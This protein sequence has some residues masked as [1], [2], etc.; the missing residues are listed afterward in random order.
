M[1]IAWVSQGT[2]TSATVSPATANYPTTTTAGNL[3]ILMVTNK[4][5]TSSPDTPSGW[6]KIGQKS[7]GI[8]ANGNDAGTMYITLFAKI[9]TGSEG[10]TTLSVSYTGTIN[11]SLLQMMQ[12]SKTQGD[13]DWKVASGTDAVA[14]TSWSVATNSGGLDIQV[15]DL[16]FAF[17]AFNGDLCT[18]VAS[19]ALSQTGTTFG[20]MTERWDDR[21]SSGSDSGFFMSEHPISSGGGQGEVTHTATMTGTGTST[22]TGP[23]I[24]LRLRENFYPGWVDK[25]AAST[26]L[27][28]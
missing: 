18:A 19:E 13:W 17:G 10:G 8:G 1:T 14:D 9:A 25:A 4:Y 28:M 12:V 11:T 16:V 21:S 26:L 22:P 23:G 6:V 3:L 24:I 27:R 2:R 5:D 20:T 7:G 15:G